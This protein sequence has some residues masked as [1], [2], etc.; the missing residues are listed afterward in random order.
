MNRLAVSEP[1]SEMSPLAPGADGVDRALLV[2][3]IPRAEIEQ[4]ELGERRGNGDGRHAGELPQQVA[5]E[6]V[7]AHAV[8]AGGDDLGPLLVLPDE[9]GRPVG[10]LV[11]RNAPDLVA[12][13]RA[14]REQVRLIVVVVLDIEAAVVQHRR[15]GGAP[16]QPGGRGL[17]VARP[18]QPAVRR[19]EAEDAQVAEVDE[20]RVAVGDRRLGRQGVLH[21]VAAGRRAAMHLALPPH[22]PGA[23]VERVDES[24]GVPPS[25]GPTSRA[26]DRGRP[27]VL[28]PAPC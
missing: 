26:R 1:R 20:Q 16:P 22:G 19:V 12:G 24:S 28:R 8:G 23:D 4:A 13:L 9:G 6:V 5:V 27:A 2:A 10:A 17:D 21:V 15:R 7:G 25:R 3:E 11:P 14:Q 18:A